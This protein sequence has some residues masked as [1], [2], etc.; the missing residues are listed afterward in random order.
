M[1]NYTGDIKAKT[2]MVY[3]MLGQA[4]KFCHQSGW[5]R[6]A[7]EISHLFDH[8]ELSLRAPLH[9]TLYCTIRLPAHRLFRDA[10][11]LHRLESWPTQLSSRK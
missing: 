9:S 7:F 5:I 4:T 11:A 8:L 10:Q 3:V 1:K 2:L 6:I